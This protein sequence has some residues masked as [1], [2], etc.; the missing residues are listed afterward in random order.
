[1]KRKM[2][3]G[4]AKASQKPTYCGKQNPDLISLVRVVGLSN[5]FFYGLTFSA[6]L[7]PAEKIA[8]TLM[9]P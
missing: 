4:M 9:K 6:K 3:P 7:V 5:S 1:M 2:T 8:P